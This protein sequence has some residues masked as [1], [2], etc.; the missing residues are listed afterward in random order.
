VAGLGLGA[1]GGKPKEE[2]MSELRLSL[3]GQVAIHKDGASVT[4][5]KS[6][7]AA[8]LL[9]YVAVTGQAVARTTLVSLLWSEL[10]EANAQMNLR[11]VLA[12]LRELVGDHLLVTRQTVAFQRESPYWLDVEH[13]AAGLKRSNLTA[14]RAALE[15]YQGDFLAGLEMRQAPLFEEWRSTERARLRSLAVDA[16]QTL[17]DQA[18]DPTQAIADLRRLLALE[19]WREMAH[20]Q[21]MERLAYSGQINAA[22][23]QYESCRQLLADQLAVEPAAATTALYERLRLAT[24]TPAHHLPVPATPFVGR[25]TEIDLIT[26]YLAD[27]LCRCLT[28]VGPGGMGKTRLALAAAT[29]QLANFLHGVVFVP[30]AAV[31][32]PEFLAPA[33]AAALQLP[34]HGQEEPTQQLLH[35]L[36]DR[37]ALLLLDNLEQLL[38]GR[39]LLAEILTQAPYV[40]ILATSRERLNLKAE[41]VIDIGGLAF[42]LA[43]ATRPLQDYNAV[44]LFVETAQR[45]QLNFALTAANAGAIRH[46]CQLVAGM[47]LGIELAAAWVRT[48]TCAEIAT[49]LARNLDLLTTTQPD[50]PERHQS[51]SAVFAHSW[52]LL[53]A[54]Q[55]TLLG[56]LAVFRRS[57]HQ[58]AAQ[59]ICGA[60]LRDLAALVDKSLLQRDEQ[61]GRFVLHELLR[62]FAAEK[63]ATTVDPRDQTVAERHCHYYLAWLATHTDALQGEE[64]NL[65]VAGILPEIDNLRQAWRWA[66]AHGEWAVLGRV[67]LAWRSFYHLCG[68][69]TEAGHWLA[70]A[71]HHWPPATADGST[72]PELQNSKGRLL[73]CAAEIAVQQAHYAQALQQAES[74]D[75]VAT[76]SA[77][78]SLKGQA[79]AMLGEIR[80]LQWAPNQALTHQQRAAPLLLQS[81]E[82]RLYAHLLLQMGKTYEQLHQW[83]RALDLQ[84]EALRRFEALGDGLGCTICWGALGAVHYGRGHLD[85][86]LA[87]TQHALAR[88]Q[89]LHAQAEIMQ[90]TAEIGRIY[91]RSRRH[92]EA[93]DQL[94]QAVQMATALGLGHKVSEYHRIL[95]ESYK[96]LRQFAQART[97]LEQAVQLAQ[98]TNAPGEQIGALVTLSALAEAEG[99]LQS[100]LD[101]SQRALQ[102]A[103]RIGDLRLLARCLGKVGQLYAKLDQLPLART[104]LEA[105]VDT[106][107]PLGISVNEP[108]VPH[109]LYRLADVLYRQGDYAAAEAHCHRALAILQ[110]HGQTMFHSKELILWMTTTLA[111]CWYAQGRR[112]EARQ[113]L[114]TLLATV[115]EPAQ[116]AKIREMLAQFQ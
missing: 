52:G 109:N 94:Q 5:F 31:S 73:L 113:Q 88:A 7:K 64:P 59:Q 106:P 103:E 45:V 37:E 104:W 51:M 87:C 92:P 76:Q 34:L 80:R 48:L 23:A 12:N 16:L 90:Y 78:D 66:V 99:N 49:E 18:S 44:Q 41:W 81:G 62:Q 13:F 68:L 86:A 42:P 96:A 54:A 79:Q 55:Q 36:Q 20:R 3:L 43:E 93:I 11:H 2:V 89:T 29:K 70:E 105:A 33:I 24:Q 108:I 83:D 25:T 47:P 77:L 111:Q 8:A 26:R 14:V 38:A 50:V 91:L 67:L 71:L 27:P 100:A 17:A 65:A 58:Q 84:D 85:Q 1:L 4:G 35:Y 63:Q 101:Y 6:S 19:P 10:G 110:E 53:P 28:L 46:I 114:L 39:A 22:L 72:D 15:L 57:F 56:Q 75:K 102:V 61:Q 60:A 40:K 98:K 69:Y 97:H 21:L 82:S 95:G 115:D 74:A 107:Q 9:C 112:E 30:L 116:Q 32:A